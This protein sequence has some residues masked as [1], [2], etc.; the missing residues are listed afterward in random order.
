MKKKGHDVAV[1]HLQVLRQSFITDED[2]CCEH[3]ASSMLESFVHST[4]ADEQASFALFLAHLTPS[5][6][7]LGNL[8]KF[9]E[10]RGKPVLCAS[11]ENMSFAVF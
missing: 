2:R 8:L 6:R 5:A 1:G 7:L 10:V 4:Q 9:L 11:I 3:I